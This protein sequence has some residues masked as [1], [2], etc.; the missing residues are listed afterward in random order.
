M[1]ISELLFILSGVKLIAQST[2]SENLCSTMQGKYLGEEVQEK[3]QYESDQ[4]VSDVK[5][6][7]SSEEK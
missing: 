6:L 4:V 7:T 2:V 5:E 1:W 3:L